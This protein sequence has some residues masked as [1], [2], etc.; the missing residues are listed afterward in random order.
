MYI[1]LSVIISRVTRIKLEITFFCTPICFFFFEEMRKQHYKTIRLLLK[2]ML[3]LQIY[4]Y[5]KFAVAE[6]TG[7][8]FPENFDQSKVEDQTGSN[9]QIPETETEENVLERPKRPARLLPLK[10][11]R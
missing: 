8:K 2:L 10:I 5:H 6:A 7:N 1:S 4:S 11:I 9:D 3:L